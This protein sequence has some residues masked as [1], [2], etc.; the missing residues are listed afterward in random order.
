MA[1]EIAAFEEF[2]SIKYAAVLGRIFFIIKIL[3]VQ[4]P[5]PKRNPAEKPPKKPSC[6][7]DGSV[8]YPKFREAKSPIFTFLLYI[9][10]KQTKKINVTAADIHFHYTSQSLKLSVM[11][12]TLLRTILFTVIS[13]LFADC[14]QS[15]AEISTAFPE[16]DREFLKLLGYET[17]GMVEREEYYLLVPDI[18]ISKAELA[19]LRNNPQTRMQRGYGL[20]TEDYQT[21]YYND[22]GIGQ[23]RS[24]LDQ[25]VIAWNGISDSNIKF[26]PD[27]SATLVV[28]IRGDMAGDAFAPLSIQNPSRSGQYSQNV[29]LN[30]AKVMPLLSDPTRGKYFMM[31]ILGHIA[32]FGHAVTDSSAMPDGKFII[33]TTVYDSESIMRSEEDI[34]NGRNGEK[35]TGF[36]SW[37]IKAIQFVYPFKEKPTISLS[38]SPAGTGADA[39]TLALGTTYK[40]TAK[41][42]YSKRPH[43]KYQITISKTSGGS[44][45]QDYEYKDLGNGVFSVRFLKAGKYKVSVVVTNVPQNNNTIERTYTVPDVVPIYDLKCTPSG[46]GPNNNNLTLGTKYYFTARYIHPLSTNPKF[47]FTIRRT[48]GS[49]E[50]YQL[51]ALENGKISVIFYN[52]GVYRI[53]VNVINISSPKEFEAIYKLPD[54][55]PA[56]FGLNC[57]PPGTNDDGRTLVA[58]KKYLFT[59]YY[60]YILS[61]DAQCELMSIEK[62]QSLL[63]PE[64]NINSDFKIHDDTSTEDIAKGKFQVT[65]YTSGQ[66]RIRIRVINTKGPTEFETIYYISDEPAYYLDCIPSWTSGD[67]PDKK[68]L[69]RGKKYF[70]KPYCYI[71][72][73]KLQCELID[74][75]GET[76]EIMEGNDFIIHDDTPIQ[77]L[78]Q[79]YFHATF[80]T[81]GQYRFRI[82]AANGTEFEEI[83]YVI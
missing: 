7:R 33:G 37:D 5:H 22:A 1:A 41:Y 54:V 66:Y 39:S 47:E 11:R 62:I 36:S 43:P 45:T 69:T 81:P 8:S 50:D 80:Y 58:H 4:R 30:Y 63:I 52:P 82:E 70:F 9:A 25:A 68:T 48:G 20:L 79:G 31:H 18:V 75:E 26:V 60:H 57:E 15:P 6:E 44:S 74:I 46:T 40:F 32:G 53:K 59:P 16:N 2:N 38:C 78:A 13:L 17:L 49:T 28:N 23:Y 19:N 14:A 10:R 24:L 29:V 21:I 73:A 67:Q 12:K 56:T 65:F 35:W 27:N 34:L 72:N 55:P 83:F 61:P 77:D 42:E 76:P 3:P 51:E 64:T 71:S